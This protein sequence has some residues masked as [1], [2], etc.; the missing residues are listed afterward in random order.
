MLSSLKIENIA[1]IES[2]EIEFSDG[3][4]VLS[5]ET[6]AGKSIIIDA[7]SSVLGERT[8]KDLIRTGASRAKVTAL[9]E[10]VSPEV[11]QTLKEL[12]LDP[13]EDQSLLITRTLQK[14]GRNVC[15]VNGS[16]VTVTILR[17][18][19]KQL[20]SIHGQHDSQNLLNSEYHYKYLDSLGGLEPLYEDYYG[21]Y[22]EYLNLYRKYRELQ[23]NA[24]DTAAR[25]DFLR[26]EVQEIENAHIRV[27]EMEELS[28]KRDLFRNS[29]KVILGLEKA[30]A[31]LSDSEEISG[32]VSRLFDASSALEQT[33]KYLPEIE[34]TAGKIT[35]A[36]YTMQDAQET[37]K[38]AIYNANYDA[39]EQA[40]V[41]DRLAQLQKLRSKY[42]PTEEDILA[43][44]E[45]EKKELYNLEHRQETTAE[46]EGELE[47]KQSA[48]LDAA[49]A[50]SRARKDTAK[51]F[52]EKVGEELRFLNMPNVVISTS[53]TPCKL[54]STGSDV[55]EFL[56]STNP[57]E[58]LKP[59]SKIAS[60]GELSRIML[61]I[62]NVLSEKGN[63]QTMIFDEI[64][65]GVSGSEAERIAK[66]LHSVSEKH[67]VLCVT[68]SAQVAS[69]A[70]AHY[71]ISKEVVDGM[72]YTR[73]R[74]LDHEGRV[75][76]LARII[77][78]EKITDLQK[79]SAEEMLTRAKA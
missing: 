64:D 38:D 23:K 18:I 77:G 61:A 74:K 53:F 1:I 19:G 35:E 37:L 31:A 21:K 33:A 22:S 75:L 71:K 79:K 15:R 69:Y 10:G 13:S 14:D 72:T 73:V 3:L 68:H 25:A 55:I 46:L 51:Q 48:L 47:T 30:L 39:Q 56:I 43:Y 2:A 12:D 24:E 44:Y 78:G 26:F 58:A 32:A 27:G 49:K 52:E 76:E 42:G 28:R 70:D 20:I 45:R 54:N 59:L 40:G 8:S 65:T 7:I 50:L 34:D 60:G 4:N 63:V 66:K 29:E 67:Q 5:G 62:Q 36:A 17:Q 9:F 41:E 16:P 11:E 6:G 57:G